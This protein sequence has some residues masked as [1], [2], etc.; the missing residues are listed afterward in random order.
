[1]SYQISTESFIL[2]C[3]VFAM[4][5]ICALEGYWR[6]LQGHKV[7]GYEAVKAEA[8]EVGLS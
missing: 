6:T 8:I 2:C 3:S 1:M 5:T 4:C 7:E